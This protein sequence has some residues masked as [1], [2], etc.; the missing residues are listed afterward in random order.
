MDL[1]NQLASFHTAELKD[2]LSCLSLSKQGRKQVCPHP[3]FK[4]SHQL[5]QGFNFAYILPKFKLLSQAFLIA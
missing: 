4:L 5:M 3:L 1:Q 2:V